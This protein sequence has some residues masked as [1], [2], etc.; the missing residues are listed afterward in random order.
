MQR[1]SGYNSKGGFMTKDIENNH[2]FNINTLPVLRSELKTYKYLDNEIFGIYE[3]YSKV[4]DALDDPI[5]EI[6]SK[7]VAFGNVSCNPNAKENEHDI[8]VKYD[9]SDVPKSKEQKYNSLL[10]QK[11]QLEKQKKKSL[12]KHTDIYYNS[13]AVARARKQAVEN[14]LSRLN[15]KDR[16][17]IMDLYINDMSFKK[18]K[19]KYKIYNDGNVS[20]K[21]NN[22]LKKMIR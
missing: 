15:T 7:L 8:L 4:C 14:V 3:E 1:I 12:S 17:F 20:R 22:I 11:E 2:G 5:K 10:Y 16:E 9:S 19:E 13:L 18:V 21:A 6:E